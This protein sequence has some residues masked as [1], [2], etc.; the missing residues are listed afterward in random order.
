M[1]SSRR[2]FL[3]AST[4]LAAF[5]RH[6]SRAVLRAHGLAEGQSDHDLACNEDYWSEI[7]RA[8]DADRTLINLNHGGVA[9]APTAVMEGMIRDLPLRQR[10]PGVSD[11]GRARTAH[12]IGPPR[13]RG[14]VWL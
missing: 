3:A 1:N 4:S 9:P 11:V 8:F 12:R 7:R 14:R 13:A 5:A 2:R 6:A 10:R